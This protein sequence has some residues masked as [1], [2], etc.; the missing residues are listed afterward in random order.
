MRPGTPHR[1]PRPG[2]DQRHALYAA[3]AL[4]LTACAGHIPPPHPTPQPSADVLSELASAALTADAH[5]DPADSLYLPGVEIIAEGRRRSA[6]PRFAGIEAQGQ[7]VVGS[8]RVDMSGDF[9]WAVV[10]YRWLASGASTIREGR[11]TLVFARTREG[12]R[13]RITHAH[14][15]LVH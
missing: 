12:Q 5:L 9:A 2:R 8:T 3:A 13:W 6:V 10:E 4:A 1:L 14:S 7:V 11:A 15:S